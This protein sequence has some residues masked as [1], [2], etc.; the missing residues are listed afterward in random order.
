MNELQNEQAYLNALAQ[1]NRERI[2]V[3]LEG[4]DTA[5]KTLAQYFNFNLTIR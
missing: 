1:N 3:I 2:A 5:G 4:R